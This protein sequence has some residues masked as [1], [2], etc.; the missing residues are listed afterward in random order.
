MTLILENIPVARMGWDEKAIRRRPLLARLPAVPTAIPKRRCRLIPNVK[1]QR[2]GRQSKDPPPRPTQDQ[3][4]QN[5]VVLNEVP[6]PK[7]P[8]IEVLTVLAG[9]TLKVIGVTQVFIVQCH[10]LFGRT[11]PHL[12]T[13]CVCEDF[14]VEMRVKGYG[15]VYRPEDGH[16]YVLELPERPLLTNPDLCKPE[17]VVRKLLAVTRM[18][19]KPNGRVKVVIDEPPSKH[20]L[21]CKFL[22]FDPL[23]VMAEKWARADQDSKRKETPGNGNNIPIPAKS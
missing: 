5:L 12:A 22:Q 23:A 8:Y 15:G 1:S 18:G 21:T 3:I 19:S 13:G 14:Q 20:F 16:Y 17:R 11:W 7:K 4:A 10:Y 2:P 9:Q 6:K